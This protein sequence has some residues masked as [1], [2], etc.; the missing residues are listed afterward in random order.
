[1]KGKQ[2]DD[3]FRQKLGHQKLNPPP[4]A[5]S[6][7]EQNLPAKKKKGAYFWMSI[8][9]G[10]LV[11]FTAG[12]LLTGQGQNPDAISP[13]IQAKVEEP[14]TEDAPVKAEEPVKVG[15][16]QKDNQEV[17]QA[18]QKQIAEPAITELV[19]KTE[20]NAPKLIDQTTDAD[21][22]MEQSSLRASIANIQPIATNQRHVSLMSASEFNFD[23]VM[24]VDVS[25]YYITQ[26]EDLKLTSKK[27][28]FRVINGII[29]IAKEVNSSKLSFSELR[30]AKNNF[31]EDDLKY[32]GKSDDNSSGEDEPNSPGK[33]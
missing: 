6:A 9:A 24:P 22:K 19:A 11:I 13:Q 25:A 10:L 8:A 15:E 32:G 4:A 27:K 20:N 14:K 18:I 5:W 31:V 7:I 3:L 26:N 23:M 21:I 17:P 28:K 30:N 16:T 2:I 33:D 1:M 12:W 29:S